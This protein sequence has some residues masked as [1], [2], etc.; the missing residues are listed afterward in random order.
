MKHICKNCKWWEVYTNTKLKGYEI[1]V[2]SNPKFVYARL[3]DICPKDGLQYW[4]SDSYLAG[5][6]T[7]EEFSCLH[8]K[9]KEEK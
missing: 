7:G 5:F 3:E 6:H 1:G 9:P 8:W 2:C 4:D